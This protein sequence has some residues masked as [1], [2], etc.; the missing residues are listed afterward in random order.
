MSVP[1]ERNVSWLSSKLLVKAQFNQVV[2][3]RGWLSQF[4]KVKTKDTFAAITCRP[5]IQTNV[6]KRTTALDFELSTPRKMQS[7]ID[8]AK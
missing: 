2:I 5:Q 8:N 4:P 6:L 1:Q 7:S 3:E